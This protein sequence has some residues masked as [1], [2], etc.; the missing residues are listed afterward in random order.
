MNVLILPQS[1]EKEW[2]AYQ[3]QSSNFKV[4][5]WAN[6]VFPFVFGK[7]LKDHVLVNGWANGWELNDP[8]AMKQFNNG[9][10]VIVFLP[11]YLEYIGFLLLL[12]TFTLLIFAHRPTPTKI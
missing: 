2:K 10:I 7:E 8:K 6:T 3:V 9:T 12:G 5:S 4:Q 1:F 11:Q